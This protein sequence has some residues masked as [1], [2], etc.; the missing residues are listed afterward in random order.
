M[1][2]AMMNVGFLAASYIFD[3]LRGPHGMG[4]H[5]H[6][7]LFGIQLSTIALYSWQAWNRNFCAAPALFPAKRSRVDLTKA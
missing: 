2:Y 6:F 1:F 7:S 5:G 4:E 3:F